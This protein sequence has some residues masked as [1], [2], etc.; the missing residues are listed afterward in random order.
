MVSVRSYVGG[1]SMATAL[2]VFA[3]SIV[4]AGLMS[5]EDVDVVAAEVRQFYQLGR[6]QGLGGSVSR[7]SHGMQQG[8]IEVAGG[9]FGNGGGQE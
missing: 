3:K 9:V 7:G 8:Q 5:A 2:D 1:T 4:A 6:A